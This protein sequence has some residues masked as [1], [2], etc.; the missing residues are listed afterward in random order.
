VSRFE[1]A[2]SWLGPIEGGVSNHKAD[3]GGLTKWGVTQGTY[4]G[5]RR[6][7]GLPELTVI[8]MT[9]YE[10]EQI[11]LEEYWQA[12]GCDDLPWPLALVHFDAAV[13]HGPARARKFIVESAGNWRRYIGLREAFY[14][15]LTKTKPSQLA[16]LSG[17]MNRMKRLT[18]LCTK[19][20]KP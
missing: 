3:K 7:R 16:F 17:W 10:K 15:Y 20:D 1:E 2:M 6:K 12:A 14:V 8:G 5:W 4:D 9:R 19:E 13:N 11:Y 18:V